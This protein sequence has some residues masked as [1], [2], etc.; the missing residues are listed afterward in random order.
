[1]DQEVVDVASKVHYSFLPEDYSDEFVEIAVT[2]KPKGKIGGDFC[3]I[4]PLNKKKLFVSACDVTGHNIASALY[5]SRINTFVFAHAM[6]YKSPC[7]AINLLNTF[8]VQKL[9]DTGMY[10]TFCA[11]IFDFKDRTMRFASAAQPPIIFFH[12]RSGQ[13]ELLRS[14]TTFLGFEDPL[15]VP[16][17]TDQMQIN[18]GD[19]ILLYSDGLIESEDKNGCILGTQGV[20]NFTKSHYSLRSTEF[21]RTLIEY[22]LNS[23]NSKIKDDI[24]LMT[25]TVK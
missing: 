19:K 6:Q 11:V 16:C 4:L 14:E 20:R 22:M 18:S 10:A 15:P 12:N 9:A 17:S 2:V 1:M 3:S 24:L 25:V 7:H 21:N 23:N 13:I 5:A 8:L